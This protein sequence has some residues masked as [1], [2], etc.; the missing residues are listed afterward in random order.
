MSEKTIDINFKKNNPKDIKIGHSYL[1]AFNKKVRVRKPMKPP[2]DILIPDSI[3][4]IFDFKLTNSGPAAQEI[5]TA[6][7]DQMFKS[8]LAHPELAEQELLS[9]KLTHAT[10]WGEVELIPQENKEPVN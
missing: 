10:Y 4:M 2:Q 5:L 3:D 9:I 6:V 8:K 7:Q 1:I